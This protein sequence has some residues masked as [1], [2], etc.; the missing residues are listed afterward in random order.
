MENPPN[1]NLQIAFGSGSDLAEM[2]DGPMP[3]NLTVLH[4]KRASADPRFFRDSSIQENHDTNPSG[5]FLQN[6][7][8]NFSTIDPSGGQ[9]A[10]LNPSP[11]A[12]VRRKGGQFLPPL[13]NGNFSQHHMSADHS[14]VKFMPDLGQSRRLLKLSIT[15]KYSDVDPNPF[16]V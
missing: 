12:V 8:S 3:K 5:S 16:I 9:S 4:K 1:R 14:N 15:D 7:T 2:Q 11:S 10:D 13:K 6:K